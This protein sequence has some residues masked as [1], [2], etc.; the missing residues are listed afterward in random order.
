M[1]KLLEKLDKLKK[2]LDETECVKEIRKLNKKIKNDKELITLIE[3]YNYTKDERIKE[4]I[5][6]NKL[7]REYK[8][9]EA[10]LNF[11]ILEINQALKSITKKD[12][13]GL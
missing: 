3:K 7:Y 6:N 9:Q 8:H 5:I 2:E 13:C 12:K 11:L 1:E 4:Q 10:E